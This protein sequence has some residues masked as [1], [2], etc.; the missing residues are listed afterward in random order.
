MENYRKQKAIE[1]FKQ[2]Y[3]CTQAI[4]LAYCDLVDLDEKI[5]FKISTGFGGGIAKLGKTCGAINAAVM[6]IRLRYA[7]TEKTDLD[8]KNKVIEM[9]RNFIVEFSRNHKGINCAE[10]LTEET[11]KRYTMHSE[12]CVNII[13]EVC[14]LLKL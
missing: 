3:N 2:G 11:D 12:K 5:A 1:L 9:T 4:L 10:L 13:D 14:E 7:G 6:L 8:S